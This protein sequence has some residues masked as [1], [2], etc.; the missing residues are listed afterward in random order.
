MA[1]NALTPNAPDLDGLPEVTAA[2]AGQ[3]GING[4]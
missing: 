1:D 3:P 4:L 2:P